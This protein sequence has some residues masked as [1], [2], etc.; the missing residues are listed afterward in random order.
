MVQEMLIILLS[1][2][3]VGLGSFQ[4]REEEPIRSFVIVGRSLCTTCL[5]ELCIFS[6]ED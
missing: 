4:L 3:S 5:A 6:A 2:K 1:R